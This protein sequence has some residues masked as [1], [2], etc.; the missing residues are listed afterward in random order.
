MIR[1][2]ALR[3]YRLAAIVMAAVLLHLAERRAAVSEITIPL[4]EVR[5]FF[6]DARTLSPPDSRAACAVWDHQGHRLGSVL[7]TSPQT[8]DLIGYSGPS[9]LLA[10]IDPDGHVVGVKILT[11]DDT[12]AH[13]RDIKR[14]NAFWRQFVGW[15]P[16]AEPLPQIEGVSGSTLTSLAM[17]EAVERRLRGQAGSRRFPQ[18]VSLEEVRAFFPEAAAL[19]EV[20]SRQAAWSRVDDASGWLLGYAVRTAPAADNVRGYRGPTESLI[21]VAVDRQAIL[22]VRLRSSFDTPEYVDRVR[23][24]AA[25]LDLLAKSRVED[26]P[27]IDFRQAGIEGV[28]GATQTSFAVAEGLRQRFAA[29]AAQTSVPSAPLVTGRN[30]CL[31]ILAIG[32]LVVSLTPLRMSRRFLT[33]W[34]V[35]AV[36]LLGIWFGDLLSL[37]TFAGWGRHGISLSA[38]PGMALLGAVA[39]LTPW[40]TR[41]NVYCQH[42][43]P[44]GIVQGWLG[45]FRR[46]HVPVSAKWRSW[47][48][49]VPA[50]LLIAAFIVAVAIPAFDLTMLEPFDAW[51]LKG[52]ATVSAAIAVIG[53]GASIFIPQAYCRFGCPTGALLKFVRSGGKHDRF[54][55][56]DLLAS[57]L[58]AGVGLSLMLPEIRTRLSP[59]KPEQPATRQITGQAFGTTWR[60]TFR[61]GEGELTGLRERIAAEL[62][63]IES[64]LSHWR[65]GS[66]TSDFNANETTLEMEAPP[67]LIQLVAFAQEL[68]RATDGAYDITVSPLVK[69][70]GFGPDGEIQQAPTD[71]ELATILER[72][73]WQKVSVD[74]EANTLKKEHPEVQIDLGSLL[75]G[76]AADRVAAVIRESSE[77]ENLEFLID[78]GGELLAV[79]SWNVAIEDPSNPARP[80]HT[81][82]LA[83]AALAT[84]GTSRSTRRVGGEKIHHLISPRTGRPV[85]M[86]ARSSSVSISS[87]WQKGSDPLRASDFQ[88]ESIALQRVRPLLRQAATSCLEAD[89]WATALWLAGP[90]QAPR[91]A[92]EHQLE[93]WSFDE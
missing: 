22:G 35:I 79:G 52:A 67:E 70:W 32:G 69:A 73:G 71:S 64:T 89:G 53:L 43:C 3:V 30:I 62:E 66:A 90:K 58:L 78:I 4:N 9:N 36:C 23:E 65:P 54:D 57:L 1:V 26:W 93:Y 80:R 12:P 61:G 34:H 87:L 81:F 51:V 49:R 91:I 27:T 88:G 15:A 41:R 2:I 38:A 85:P 45:R 21:A 48:G 92:V 75:Q 76:Y 14:H 37:A 11:S 60:V 50:G 29:D 10:A 82:V 59:R 33:A 28:S 83:N 44:H 84:S 46:C 20:E 7:T 17:T 24:D 56:R 18:Q 19:H 40:S 13:V 42:L 72:V 68:S 63:R 39:L 16:E 55:I 77:Q 86:S 6:P 47:L 31:M 74:R 25:F 5:A 8:D